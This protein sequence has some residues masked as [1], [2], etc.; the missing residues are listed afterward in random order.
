MTN[1]FNEYGST[2]GDFYVVTFCL[3][4]GVRV[5]FKPNEMRKSHNIRDKR[6]SSPLNI[7]DFE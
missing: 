7:N 5:P 3:T 1:R 2:V 6:I 4:S